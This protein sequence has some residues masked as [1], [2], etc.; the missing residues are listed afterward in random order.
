M[1]DIATAL[2]NAGIGTEGERA[3]FARVL[4]P[5]PQT[6]ADALATGVMVLGASEGLKVIEG[7]KGVEAMWMSTSGE[8]TY[9]AGFHQFS[10]RLPKRWLTEPQRDE[11]VVDPLRQNSK[12]RAP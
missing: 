6:M 10:Q 5:E 8:I 4:G 2:Q 12:G 3:Q 11:P 1:N 9:S 7:L